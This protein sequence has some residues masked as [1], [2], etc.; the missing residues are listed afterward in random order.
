MT[1]ADRSAA[2]LRACYADLAVVTVTVTMTVTVDRLR[3]FLC[4]CA[5]PAA[6]PV[7]VHNLRKHKVT[8]DNRKP[9]SVLKAAIGAVL[10]IAVSEFKLR[11]SQT[12]AELRDMDKRISAN[13]FSD[14]D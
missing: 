14:G 7:R 12:D 5:A 11:K 6:P 8:V 4:A 3:S 13:N 10:H 1:C 9:M 2:P